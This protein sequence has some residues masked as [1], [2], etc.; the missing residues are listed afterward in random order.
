[1]RPDGQRLVFG[2]LVARSLSGSAAVTAI[3]PA[4]K[5]GAE[6]RVVADWAAVDAMNLRCREVIPRIEDT[7]D[8]NK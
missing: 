8:I 1:M 2:F 5:P 4:L 3:G 7:L 6:T